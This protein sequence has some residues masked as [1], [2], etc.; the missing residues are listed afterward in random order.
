M[1]WNGRSLSAYTIDNFHSG[2]PE[3]GYG[4]LTLLEEQEAWDKIK[5]KLEWQ[6]RN[7]KITNAQYTTA[8]QTLGTRPTKASSEGGE[9]D[10][11]A[12]L[13]QLVA[14]LGS[15]VAGMYLGNLQYR[16]QSEAISRGLTAGSPPLVTSPGYVTTSLPFGVS[17]STLLFA[18][19][20]VGALIL[21]FMMR[22]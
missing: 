17:S 2:Y 6:K 18:G 13:P 7:N 5:D 3:M 12:I 8:I 20:G 15:S 21:I 4:A 1:A 9:S 11:V 14:T 19:L 16:L 10:L 22:R